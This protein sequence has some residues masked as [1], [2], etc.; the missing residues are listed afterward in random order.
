MAHE[1][2]EVVV[3]FF[4]WSICLARNEDKFFSIQHSVL[5]F[6]RKV[7]RF[8]IDLT[9][10]IFFAITYRFSCLLTLGSSFFIKRYLLILDE[11][12]LA[13][14]YPKKTFIKQSHS[15]TIKF[16]SAVVKINLKC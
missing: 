6:Q 5:V 7:T 11:T 9:I 2:L 16:E 4:I 10:E 12:F 3:Q 15:N 8:P 13:G 14:K 1:G